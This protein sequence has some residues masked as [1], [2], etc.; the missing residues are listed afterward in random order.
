MHVDDVLWC[1][2]FNMCDHMESITNMSTRETVGLDVSSQ[3]SM[4]CPHL[5][6]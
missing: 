3:Q 1:V 6:C 5:Q 2:Y 4:K